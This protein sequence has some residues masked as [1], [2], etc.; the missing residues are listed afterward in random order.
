MNRLESELVYVMGEQMPAGGQKLE[1]VPGVYWVRMPLPF[2]LDHINLYLLKDRIDGRDG[3]TLIDCGIASDEIRGH[4]ETIFANELEGLPLLRVICTHMHPDHI[5]LSAWIT[6]RFECKL[7]MTM[8]EYALGRVLSAHLPGADSSSTVEHYSRNGISDTAALEGLAKRGGDYFRSLV[9]DMP[10]TFRRLRPDEKVMIN[11]ESWEVIIGTGHSPEHAALYCA[12]R[13]LLL[14]GDMILPRISTNV[15]VFELEQEANP[16]RWFLD[17]I[18]RFKP[19][20]AT[21]LVFPSHG[22]PFRNLH[23]RIEQLH[24]H[25]ADRLAEVRAECTIKA[26]SAMD[27]VPVM[28]RRPLDLHQTTFALGEALAHLHLLWFDDELTRL[29]DDA[30]V[31]RF[32]MKSL[33]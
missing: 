1:V 31:V 24:E 16:L 20:A 2:A 23:R 3:W 29:T 32:K 25:H 4:W 28:F 18:D 17:S 13:E 8:G 9:P 11:G 14:S 6:S 22:K 19:C 5:G 15:S 33:K 10:R 26:C 27:I 7:W 30:G 12:N 21:T